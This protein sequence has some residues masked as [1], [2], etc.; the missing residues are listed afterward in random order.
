M[1][2]AVQRVSTEGCFYAPLTDK[3]KKRPFFF[4]EEKIWEFRTMALFFVLDA[5]PYDCMVQ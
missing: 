2:C 5:L 1:T 3:K 4:S